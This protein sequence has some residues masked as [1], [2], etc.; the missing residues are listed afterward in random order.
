MA[1]RALCDAFQIPRRV[2]IV[3][4]NLAVVRYCADAGRLRRPELRA[5]LDADLARAACQGWRIEWVAVRRRHNTGADE[6]ATAGCARAAA[7][8]ERGVS[9]PEETSETTPDG[10]E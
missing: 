9:S 4:D 6:A 10:Q 3:G 5:I 8:A 2:R 1:L 7:L